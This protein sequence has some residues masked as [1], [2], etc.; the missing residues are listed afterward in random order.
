MTELENLKRSYSNVLQYGMIVGVNK[1]E[2][3]HGNEILHKFC[4]DL[5]KNSM[6]SDDVKTYMKNELQLLKQR[7]D[8][9]IEAAYNK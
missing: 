2:A 3:K 7:L 4:E 1:T 6:Y 8:A 9:E 5:V